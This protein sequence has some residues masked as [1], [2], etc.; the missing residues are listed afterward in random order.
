[1]YFFHQVKSKTD[2]GQGKDPTPP[3]SP[4]PEELIVPEGS[5]E[6]APTMTPQLTAFFCKASDI[7]LE[8]GTQEQIEVQFQILMLIYKC[9]TYSLLFFK[10]DIYALSFILL[11]F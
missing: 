10:D 2:H 6:V 4:P 7:V 5:Q 11:P 9:K 1:M 3:S 8:P